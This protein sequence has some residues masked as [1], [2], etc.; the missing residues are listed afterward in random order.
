ME[1]WLLEIA[2]WKRLEEIRTYRNVYAYKK[3]ISQI[4]LISPTVN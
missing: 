2:D 3:T 1:N 4:M